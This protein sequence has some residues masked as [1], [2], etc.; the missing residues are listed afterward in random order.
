MTRLSTD[1]KRNEND[2][3]E[4]EHTFSFLIFFHIDKALEEEFLSVLQ[5]CNI[6]QHE[7]KN[8]AVVPHLNLSES[9]SRSEVESDSRSDDESLHSSIQD[10]S[11]V[12][13]CSGIVLIED[14][15]TIEVAGCDCF[16]GKFRGWKSKLRI[17]NLASDDTTRSPLLNPNA[18][19]ERRSL[20]LVNIEEG[21][22]ND[23]QDENKM[24][25]MNQGNPR[26]LDEID[27]ERGNLFEEQS[28]YSI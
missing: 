3:S 25:K 17:K 2:Y 5:R 18:I 22:S 13:D 21:W 15:N 23:E 19:H 4:L 12:R 24:Y 6:Y 7:N 1:F 9:D 28:V 11:H 16:P 8:I 20:D 14:T 10:S 27:R 26:G